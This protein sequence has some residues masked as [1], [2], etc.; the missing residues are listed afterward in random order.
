MEAFVKK[1]GLSLSS[2]KDTKKKT[3][4]K[5][6][7][8]EFKFSELETTRRQAAFERELYELALDELPSGSL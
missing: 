2:F 8:N 4:L 1:R 6:K 3:S 7:W 5:E